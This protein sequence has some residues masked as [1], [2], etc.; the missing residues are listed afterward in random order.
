[1]PIL[2][3]QRT[4][5]L[6]SQSMTKEL[7][8]TKLNLF[9]SSNTRASSENDFVASPPILESAASEFEI[10][11]LDKSS[12]GADS[13]LLSSSRRP[14]QSDDQE[15]SR[16]IF[17]LNLRRRKPI[18]PRSSSSH[19][20]IDG[21]ATA[22]QQHASLLYGVDSTINSINNNVSDV[23]KSPRNSSSKDFKDLASETSSVEDPHYHHYRHLQQQTPLMSSND[24]ARITKALTSSSDHINNSSSNNIN[25]NS[26]NS[27]VSN[28]NNS[29]I[30]THEDTNL[31]VPANMNPVS[32][33]LQYSEA[34]SEACEVLG[35][36]MVQNVDST[37][38]HSFLDNFISQ[39]PL[40]QQ[41]DYS[42]TKSSP[43]S[44]SSDDQSNQISPS[45][46][47]TPG[48][49][50]NTAIPPSST[51]SPPLFTSS[52]TSTITKKG[53]FLT[54]LKPS[55]RQQQQQQQQH[56]IKYATPASGSS[57][58]SSLDLD[59]SRVSLDLS[60]SM[61]RKNA[62]KELMQ[63]ESK[64]LDDLRV[65]VTVSAQSNDN[66]ATHLV[67]LYGHSTFSRS[68]RTPNASHGNIESSLCGM[69]RRSYDSKKSLPKPWS[70]R[71][72]TIISST[73]SPA[74]PM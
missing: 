43:I 48:I 2:K 44:L 5:H 29:N 18:K 13:F 40:E 71:M 11:M 45:S 14:S 68:S 28:N 65:L 57:S 10:S 20:S 31:A 62:I 34:T 30:Y 47:M 27:N 37:T 61:R 58:T 74:H 53:S 23:E 12:L 67:L 17:S 3:Q 16:S 41:S 26:S 46:T 1:M 7:L 54:K 72:A 19:Q 56:H 55:D 9:S 70:M 73:S 35:R 51:S 49:Q 50:G 25:N 8:H 66:A 21:T 69:G 22:K 24:I 63:T 59:R 4:T 42:P 32:R 15:S 60:L 6:P 64:Y 39:H 36:T 52:P 33:L 38:I